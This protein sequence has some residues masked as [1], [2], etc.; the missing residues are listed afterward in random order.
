MTVT[1]DGT[2]G[3]ITPAIKFAGTGSATVRPP[4]TVGAFTQALPAQDGTFLVSPVALLLPSN[5]GSPGY[6]LQTDGSGT[7]SWVSNDPGITINSSPITGGLANSILYDN[8]GVAGEIP[9]GLGVN[10]T[11]TQGVNG[12]LGFAVLNNSGALAISNGGTGAVT[13]A[14]GA[15]NL[16]PNQA[17]QAGKVLSTDGLGNL[18]WAANDTGLIVGSTAIVGGGPNSLLLSDGSSLLGEVVSGSAGQILTNGGAGV[19]PLWTT[20][21]YPATTTANQLL[22]SS[23]TNTVTAGNGG[24]LNTGATGV[25]S[26]SHTP[27]LGVQGTTQ[28][29]LILANTNAGAFPATI[30]S[31]NAAIAATTLTLPPNAGASGNLL[32]TDGAGVLSWATAPVFNYTSKSGTYTATDSDYIIN[33]TS[34]T[35]Q[36]SLPA[37]ASVVAGKIYNVKN[38][39]AGVITVAANGAETIDGANTRTLNQYDNVVVANTATGSWIVL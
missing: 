35:F 15:N 21:T 10:T 1:I 3:V 30:Q 17:G 8:A 39:G 27:T 37:S 9:T 12:P 7:L 36:V 2:L 38:S 14:A 24:V 33:C 6:V 22:Y 19:N 13:A 23:A 20:A 16:L 25:P 4:V 11:L 5:Y 32:S 18:S 29:Q 26:I 31:S 34:G 28:G